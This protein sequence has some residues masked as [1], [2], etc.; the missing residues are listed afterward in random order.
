MKIKVSSG[1]YTFVKSGAHGFSI[2]IL[3]HGEKWIE[4]AD[5]ANALMSIM[6]ELDAARVVLAATRALFQYQG[7]TAEVPIKTFMGLG[8][9]LRNA[10]KRHDALVDDHEP[11]SEW[12]R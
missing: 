10:L 3:R 4:N 12:T 7:T 2:D 9:A 6:C 11:P 1:K 5:G 8:E